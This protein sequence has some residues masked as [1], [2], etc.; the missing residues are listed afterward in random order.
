MVITMIKLI[1]N[2]AIVWS[3]TECRNLEKIILYNSKNTPPRGYYYLLFVVKNSDAQKS[4]VAYPKSNNHHVKIAI[5]RK[6]PVSKPRFLNLILFK[7]TGEWMNEWM[8]WVLK[9]SLASCV[10]WGR[11]VYPFPY[12]LTML[13]FNTHKMS[14]RRRDVHL[15]I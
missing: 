15:C 14:I 4:W 5:I 10:Y 11:G 8:L 13:Q 1:T 3:Y 12:I 2:I 6:L 9:I 7:W